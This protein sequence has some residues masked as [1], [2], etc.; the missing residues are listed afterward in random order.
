MNN[1]L[2]PF[3]PENLVSRDVFGSPSRVSLLIFHT[4][5]ESG[6][7][8]RDSSR[9]PRRGPFIYT[10]PPYAI[11]SAPSSSGHAMAYRWRSLPRVR[12]HRASSPQGTV[13]PVTSAAFAG[14]TMDQLLCVSL[15]PHLIRGENSQNV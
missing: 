13:V 7:Y 5:A 3:A 1:S 14:I 8:S 11:G 15:F 4:Q 2:S 12:R 9:F 6:A 10:V